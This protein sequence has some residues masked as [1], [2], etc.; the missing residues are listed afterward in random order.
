MLVLCGE[1]LHL[2]AASFRCCCKKP[3]KSAQKLSVNTPKKMVE[4]VFSDS[5][6]L[7]IA[8][9]LFASVFASKTSFRVGVPTLLFFMVI[10]MIAGSEG[11]GIEF[12][13]PQAAQFIGV[14]ALNFILFFGGFE[15]SFS[16]IRPAIK[17]G[18]MLSSGCCAMLRKVM[19]SR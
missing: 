16:E 18:A 19:V 10:G 6:L 2:C 15:T 17:S 3:E 14:I 12:D 1:N 5:L 7:M 8:I 9:L 11:V 13:S 4:L